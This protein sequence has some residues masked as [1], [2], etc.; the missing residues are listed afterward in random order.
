[1][2]KYQNNSKSNVTAYIVQSSTA[3]FAKKFLL[4]RLTVA[5]KL[6]Y[7]EI[8]L[9]R[10]GFLLIDSMYD[11]AKRI[12][13]GIFCSEI[14]FESGFKSVIAPLLRR[15][16]FLSSSDRKGAQLKFVNLSSAPF[17]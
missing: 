10:K 12:V 8:L 15:A 6:H 2:I 14:A 9:S 3:R 11:T 5:K 16:R 1:M 13:N 4:F 7:F 17:Y